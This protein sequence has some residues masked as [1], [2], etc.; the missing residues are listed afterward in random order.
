M[1]EG[2]YASKIEAKAKEY[3]KSKR[4]SLDELL[5]VILNGDLFEMFDDI[6]PKDFPVVPLSFPN[7]AHYLDVW[8]TLFTYEVYSMLLNS[9][10]GASKE[11]SQHQLN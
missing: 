7:H 9:R 8:E 6:K 10:R 1:L 2:Q 11:E 3:R 5:R 4:K